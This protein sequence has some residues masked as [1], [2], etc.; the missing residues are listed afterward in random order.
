MDY[1]NDNIEDSDDEELGA[2]EICGT[3]ANVSFVRGLFVCDDCYEDM[4]PADE[5]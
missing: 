2:C 3:Q 4:L 1:D 5:M